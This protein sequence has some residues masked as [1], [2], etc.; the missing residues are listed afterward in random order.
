MN[1]ILNLTLFVVFPAFLILVN[2]RIIFLFAKVGFK[3]SDFSN[4]VD[5]ISIFCTVGSF[6]FAIQ[7]FLIPFM[8]QSLYNTKKYIRYVQATYPK[9]WQKEHLRPLRN[10]SEFLFITIWSSFISPVFMLGWTFFR[11]DVV[12]LLSFYFASI[13]IFGLFISLHLTRKNFHCMFSH[14]ETDRE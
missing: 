4:P 6:L 3:F 1:R 8:R 9:T 11:C 12:L 10:L 14:N 5:W 13:S 2:E 7:S